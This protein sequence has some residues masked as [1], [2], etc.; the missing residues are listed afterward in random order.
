VRRV[1]ARPIRIIPIYPLVISTLWLRQRTAALAAGEAVLAVREH[2]AR[3]V[4]VLH[5]AVAVA[6]V[7]RT[8]SFYKGRYASI[9]MVHPLCRV[10]V[11]LRYLA[12]ARAAGEAVLAVRDKRACRVLVLYAAT[13]VV[14]PIRAVVWRNGL[15]ASLAMVH[16]VRGPAVWL[17][18]RAA[19]LA[20][21]EAV[22]AIRIGPTCCILVPYAIAAIV[23]PSRA[24]VL[25]SGGN[26]DDR[27]LQPT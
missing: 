18:Y 19:A 16:P 17:R 8:V 9:A 22:L 6:V 25:V 21:G 10:A 20:A 1:G 15:Y 11:W 12:A 2:R 27:K 26:A 3:R 14:V 13:T 5:A 7:R 24:V 23:V 4:L